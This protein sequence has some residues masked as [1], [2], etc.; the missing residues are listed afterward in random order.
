M[1]VIT[2][3]SAAKMILRNDPHPSPP[4][5]G[6]TFPQGKALRGD[7]IGICRKSGSFSGKKGLHF[8][9][10]GAIIPL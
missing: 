5:G 2:A 3:R 1:R 10:K 4:G 9:E 6:D 8:R 7:F